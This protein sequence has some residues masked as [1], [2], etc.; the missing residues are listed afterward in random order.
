MKILHV[1]E[2]FSLESGGL[3]TVI[4]DLNYYLNK[5]NFTS[6]IL[7]AKEELG[8]NIFIVNTNN[9]PWLYSKEWEVKL[10]SLKEKYNFD[11][12]HI[13]GV[14]MYPQ[15][16]ASKF[17]IKNDI[18]FIVSIHG[19]YEPWLWEK[20]KLKKKLYFNLL[21]KKVFSR[22]KLL[23]AITPLEKTNLQ[24]LFKNNN[25]IEIPNL[26]EEISCE[27]KEQFKIKDDV[28]YILYLGRLDEKKGIDLLLKSFSKLNN[29]DFKIVIAGK[30]NDYQKSLK[31]LIN[32]LKLE[33]K[34]EFLGMVKGKEKID[35]I[36]NAFVL[37]APSYSEVI[38][39]VNLEAGILKTPVI[40]TFQTGLKMDWNSNGGRLINPNV[41]EL[42]DVLKEVLSW[43]ISQRN[44]NGEKLYNFVVKNY[45][46][47][48][49]F[50]D[51]KKLYKK[52]IHE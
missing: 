7:S 37:V 16:I 2:D 33:G 5:E 28:N 47:S 14:W 39:M 24:S 45:S 25:V 10:N 51:W 17:C 6:Y 4:K 50:K 27:E 42:S 1:V 20:G 22:A 11:V 32:S 52:C 31:L 19:M 35:L 36:K 49:R 38:G 30:L 13:H 48:L 29:S 21:T 15:Y 44:K 41:N 3:R 43:S 26:I 8:D 23:H 18:P 34:V 40:T 46:W 9:S 12:V